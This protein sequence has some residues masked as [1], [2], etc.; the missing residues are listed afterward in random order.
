MSM[1]PS[2]E[3]QQEPRL[4]VT[5]STHDAE[6]RRVHFL[7][8]PEFSMMGFVSAIEPLRVAN[9]FR[10]N[11][12][13]WRI[14]SASGE[15]VIASN[16]M[17]LN[18]DGPP[19][20]PADIH[21]VMVV[22]GFEPLA[23]LTP[24][25]AGWL[26]AA[27]Q[28]GAVVG[29]VDTGVFVLAEAGVVGPGPVTLHWEA[30]AAFCERYPR[31]IVTQE[32]FEI[33]PACITCAGGTAAIDMMLA[34][35]ATRHGHALAAQVSEQFVLGRIRSP[36]DHQ[37]LEIT[38]RYRVHN[39]KIIQAIRLMQEHLED[40]LE[41]DDLARL[42]G[43]SRRQ[44]ERLFAAHLAQTPLDFY[45][46][47]RLERARALLKQSD[48]GV[49]A[50]G[51]ACGFCSPSHFSRSYRAKFGVSPKDDRS[52]PQRP[53]VLPVIAGAD[54]GAPLRDSPTSIV[55]DVP[56]PHRRR[57]AAGLRGAKDPSH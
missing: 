25:L 37:R 27:R 48:M 30:Q 49:I 17:S 42:V 39:R 12:Y 56:A 7:L 52:A 44:L 11:S 16:G 18:A 40:P 57:N 26:R 31:I 24:A 54:A 41:S 9:R 1:T 33:G 15:P 32:L 51:I 47:L 21:T 38:A 43:V 2:D 29:A 34:L 35:I 22:A 8:L 19:C 50:V 23:A 55:A 20:N 4:P 3:G 14:L 10:A 13:Q 36:S 5:G 45:S 53:P 28:G 46:S 6:P